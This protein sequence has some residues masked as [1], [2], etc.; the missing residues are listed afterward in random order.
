MVLLRGDKGREEDWQFP[1]RMG[2]KDSVFVE[3]QGLHL[4]ILA[5]TLF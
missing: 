2:S 4:S 1:L 5:S 3:Y